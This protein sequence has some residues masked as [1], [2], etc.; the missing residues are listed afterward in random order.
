MKEKKI[1]DWMYDGSNK[2]FIILEQDKII[3]FYSTNSNNRYTNSY[4]VG[5]RHYNKYKP[6]LLSKDNAVVQMTIEIIK[7]THKKMKK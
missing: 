5:R 4:R 2:R 3:K 7:N 1:Y 6:N